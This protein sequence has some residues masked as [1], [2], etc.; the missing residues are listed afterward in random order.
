MVSML[1][2]GNDARITS[3]FESWAC[4]ASSTRIPA[5]PVALLD[6]GQVV[7]GVIEKPGLLRVDHEAVGHS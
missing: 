4:E 1:N 6:Y 5:E 2:E 3:Q 7:S